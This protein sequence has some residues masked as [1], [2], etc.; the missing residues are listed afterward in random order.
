M[1]PKD[2]I[3]AETYHNEGNSF[4]QQKKFREALISYNKSL[5]FSLPN[6]QQLATVFADRAAVYLELNQPNHCLE[7]VQFAR[8]QNYPYQDELEAYETKCVELQQNLCND[9][10]NDPES[11]IKLSHPANE[12]IPFI[13]NCLEMH[14]N[15]KFG[16]HLVTNQDL[17][18]GD[19]IA[20]EEPFMKVININGRYTNCTYCLKSNMLNLIPCFCC[21]NGKSL[22]KSF[23][24][25]FKVFLLSNFSNVLQSKLPG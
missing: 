12:K 17:N 13:V 22:E 14:K 15:E 3:V 23:F 7:N 9:P 21:S 24:W 2:N 16:R 25:L 18:P 4:F 20:L 8:D 10:E 1:A 5:C 6:S 19:I 11:F